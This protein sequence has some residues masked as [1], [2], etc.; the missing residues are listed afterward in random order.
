M[1]IPD[2]ARL[3]TALAEA[4]EVFE[5]NTPRSKQADDFHIGISDLGTCREWERWMT[6]QQPPTDS[7]SKRKAFIGS[8][9]GERWEEAIAATFPQARRKMEVTVTL[10]SGA[11]YVG[12]PDLV[13]PNGVLDLKSV[14]GLTGVRRT[15]PDLQKQFQ[16]HL[17]AAGLV[18]AGELDKDCWVGNAWIDR[19]GRD[20]EIV[21]SIESYDPSWLIRVDE[22]VSDVTY[23]VQYNERT[24]QDMPIE[25]CEKCCEFF[26]ICRGEDVRKDRESRGLITDAFT[27][28]YVTALIEAKNQKK[29]AEKVIEDCRRALAD[30]S[31]TTGDYI[32]RWVFVDESQVPGHTR[33]AYSKLDVRKIPRVKS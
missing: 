16:R 28:D 20:D 31:G 5:S 13:L 23:A 33:A 8:A 24:V 11:T 27:L 10:P 4:I 30:V 21:V 32:V 22:W 19:S 17:Y 9:L 3:G 7:P 25:W 29:Q 14:D 1:G 2:P 18:Q 6:I 15:G 12:H 26:S